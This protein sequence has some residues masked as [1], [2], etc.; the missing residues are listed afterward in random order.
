MSLVVAAA[1]PSAYWYL[2]RGTGAVSLVLLT[3]SVVLGLM[4]SLRFAAAPRWPRFAID[5]LHRDVSLLVIAVLVIHIVTSVLDTF[6]PVKIADAVIP[7]ASSYRPLWMGLGALSFDL[8]LALVA[9][10]LLRRRL[11]YGAWRAIHWLAYAAWPVAVLHGLGTGSDT[12][13]GW[14]LALTMACTAVV[15]IAVWL[16]IA[17]ADAPA[18]RVPAVAL[19]VATPVAI[20]IFT[21]AGPLQTGWARR[22]GT[23]AA[24][25]P[26]SP[27]RAA[28]TTTRPAP[29]PAPAPR[30]DTLKAPFAATLNGTAV[31]TQEPA[32]AIVDL[33]L[34]VSGGARG[35]LR[36]R[37]AGAPLG[38]GGLSMTG[39]QVDLSAVGLA[40]VLQGRILSLQGQQFLARV[41]DRTGSVL[42]LHANLNIDS[43]T[44]AVTGTLSA[45]PAGSSGG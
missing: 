39:S 34:R 41:A 13:A 22:A 32:G 36:V 3:A 28:L 14:M 15:L 24:L 9:T 40:S 37:L 26:K 45:R 33:A 12:K 43:Q 44:G 38:G 27:V 21:L 1:G 30:T 35:Q 7:L 2:A 25:L 6:A 19:A 18:V 42:D 4:G 5:S 20:A 11:G 10:S 16:R 23:P 29:A 17:R 8:L 31:Q